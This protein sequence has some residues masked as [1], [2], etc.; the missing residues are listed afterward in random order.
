M[1]EDNEPLLPGAILMSVQFQLQ[2][3]GPKILAHPT[4]DHFVTSNNSVS[5]L[6]S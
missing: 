1:T 2:G 3:S 6:W 5:E 4:L